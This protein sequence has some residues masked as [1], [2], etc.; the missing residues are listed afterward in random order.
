MLLPMLSFIKSNYVVGSK[1]LTWLSSVQSSS[2][3][4]FY[5]LQ[6]CPIQQMFFTRF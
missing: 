2:L 5:L 3:F 1:E 6:M 4:Y